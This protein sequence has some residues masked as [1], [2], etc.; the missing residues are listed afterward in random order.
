MKTIDRKLIVHAPTRAE[1]VALPGGGALEALAVERMWEEEK[2]WNRSTPFRRGAVLRPL[3]P[4]EFL[5]GV[6]ATWPSET[7][8]AT[9]AAFP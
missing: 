6:Q 9:A 1:A 7:A 4:G 2:N 8:G 5:Q 3:P